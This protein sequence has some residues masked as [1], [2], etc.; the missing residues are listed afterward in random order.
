MFGS[1]AAEDREFCDRWTAQGRPSMQVPDAL[2][3]H[4]HALS[5]RAFVRQHHGYGRGARRFRSGRRIAGRPVRIDPADYL[6]SLLHAVKA[7]PFARGVAL[8]GGTVLAHTAYLA[9]RVRESWLVTR[10]TPAENF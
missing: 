10:S 3:D 8:A 7:R 9:G 5:L 2:V 4:M 1:G 6:A